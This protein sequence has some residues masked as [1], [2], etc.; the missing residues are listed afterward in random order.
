MPQLRTR[1]G[2]AEGRRCGPARARGPLS[3]GTHPPK[4]AR[5]H[6]GTAMPLGPRV[7][8]KHM[9]GK[10]SQPGNGRINEVESEGS[11]GDV[12]LTTYLSCFP[13]LLRIKIRLLHPRGA[14][15]FQFS[16]ILHL[17]VQKGPYHPKP[18]IITRVSE[19]KGIAGPRSSSLQFFSDL[20]PY[21]GTA[22]TSCF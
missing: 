6:T 19:K 13:E 17:P 15:L 14:S 2:A 4:P 22:F 18:L 10:P 8:Q 3:R 9:I 21:L 5:S 1:S 16:K 12:S 7:S 11:G 20:I